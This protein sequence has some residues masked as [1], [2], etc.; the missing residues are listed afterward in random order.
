MYKWNMWL[1]IIL[2]NGCMPFQFPILSPYPFENDKG[3]GFG[4]FYCGCTHILFDFV[5]D[6]W[7]RMGKQILKSNVYYNW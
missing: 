1:N 6:N 4:S 2:C 3:V 7:M 5:R